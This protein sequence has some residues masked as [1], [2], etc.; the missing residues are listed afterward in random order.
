MEGFVSLFGN[1]ELQEI[2]AELA[3]VVKRADQAENDLKN[4]QKKAGKV[5]QQRQD[6]ENTALESKEGLLE[7]RQEIERLS[8]CR[9]RAEK[10]ASYFED[11][12][13]SLQLGID[14]ATRSADA[15][16]LIESTAKAGQ[17][18]LKAENARLASEIEGLLAKIERLAR[19][20]EKAEKVRDGNGGGQAATD[21]SR[22]L[23]NEIESL[24]RRL[25][26]SDEM[27]RVA[28]RKA[29][30]NRRAW[31]ITQMQLDLAEDKLCLLATGK[32][33]PVLE[34]RVHV[35]VAEGEIVVPEDVDGED[36]QLEELSGDDIPG[37]DFEVKPEVAGIP[38]NG[39]AIPEFGET[40]AVAQ[41]PETEF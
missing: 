35:E 23:M 29:E 38:E 28:Q 25:A 13:E 8:G 2:R 37:Y 30:H 11:R 15:A 19:G 36:F 31:L 14:T 32:P 26:E 40:P 33:R 17:A 41:A 20:A 3:R 9:V 12:C 16:A 6:N 4:L 27:R 7:A 10:A 22:D 1:R 21:G 39:K 5:E 24:R 18:A 34:S